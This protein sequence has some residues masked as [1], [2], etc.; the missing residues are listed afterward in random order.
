MSNN[1]K[2]Y[3]DWLRIAAFGFLILFH[4]GMLYV[5]WYYNIK[6][7]RIYPDLELLMITVTPWRLTLLFFISGVA[8]NFLLS[9]LGPRNFSIDRFRRLL[10]VVL[11]GILIL[12]PLQVYFEFLHKEIIPIG[13][14]NF[15]LNSY[16]SGESF[17]NRTLPSWDHLWFLVYLLV[18]TL[19]FA[20]I[21]KLFKSRNPANIPLAYILILPGFWLSFTNILIN[22]I[23]PVTQDLVSDW[24]NHLRWGG[25]FTAG[26][27]CA[28]RDDF[29]ECIR[30][31]RHSLLKLTL[32]GLALQLGNGVLWRAGYMDP[33]WD[34]IIFS[35]IEGFYGWLVVL[36][37][38]GFA[39]KYLNI[40]SKT[41]SYFTDAILPIY[42]IHQPV[43]IASAFF[44]LP[45]SLP[46]V[47]EVSTLIFITCIG[48]IVFFE[49][50]VRRIKVSRIL[51]GLKIARQGNLIGEHQT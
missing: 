43:L 45:L 50:L 22:E 42:V 4:V 15:W 2:Y 18:Y 41:L 12:N 25:I 17:P 24:A 37:L 23:S 11:F 33:F 14:F 49:I 10:I 27:I 40:N 6:S 19:C 35:I 36:T 30:R 13:Y 16:L 9:K 26:I 51:F 20:L 32:F 31:Y 21:Y 29:W 39:F 34:G 7:D 38:S 44:I 1:R 46:L 47:V 28:K 3:L 8:S 5:P 48:S